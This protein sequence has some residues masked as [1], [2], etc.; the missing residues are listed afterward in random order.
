MGWGWG[1]P[2]HAESL[3]QRQTWWQGSGS[4]TGG[5][6]TDLAK[7]MV[8][9]DESVLQ[10]AA[11]DAAQLPEHDFELLY[12]CERDEAGERIED[13]SECGDVEDFDERQVWDGQLL[14]E[15]KSLLGTTP[16]HGTI[17]LVDQV[18][19]LGE[20]PKSPKAPD[21]S[22]VM[23]HRDV[24][25]TTPDIARQSFHATREH[26]RHQAVHPAGELPDEPLPQPEEDVEDFIVRNPAPI[27]PTRLRRVV[28]TRQTPSLHTALRPALDDDEDSVNTSS[29]LGDHESDVEY[30]SEG[31]EVEGEDVAA[32]SADGAPHSA[33]YQRSGEAASAAV[34]AAQDA[35]GPSRGHGGEVPAGT[36]HP[37][38]DAAAAPEVAP[39][40]EKTPADD[41]M[42]IDPPNEVSLEPTIPKKVRFNPLVRKRLVPKPAGIAVVH[43]Q[44]GWCLLLAG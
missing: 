44:C 28:Y 22:A 14:R 25:R 43:A 40:G 38:A 21:Q 35:A 34:P 37:T 3:H 41:A 18:Y 26:A 33:E 36:A 10:P 17:P 39:G 23:F 5:V 1:R 29:L 12:S 24:S 8:R 19:G 6:P 9:Y 30:S 16:H 20:Q 13:G 7:H 4:A 15:R 31:M 2:Q 42:D 32:P 11:A 27:V